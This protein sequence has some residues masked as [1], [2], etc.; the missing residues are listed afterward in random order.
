M[1]TIHS[2]SFDIG[3]GRTITIETGKMAR[4]ADGS[5]LIKMGNCAILATVVANKEPKPGQSFFPLSVD[6]QENFLL[7]VVFR[8]LSLSAKGA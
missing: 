2:K 1:F 4:Q 3:D 6:Y 8:D 5:A 7:P